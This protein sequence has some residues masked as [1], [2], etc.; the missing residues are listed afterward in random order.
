MR[1]LPLSLV[2][3]SSVASA[4]VVDR[5]AAVVEDEVISLSQVYDLGSDYIKQR[6]ATGG[7]RCNH[8]MELEVLD[9]LI[10]RVL[11]R[12]ELSRL[13]MRVTGKEIDQAINRMVAENG[14]ND[15]QELREA[16]ARE[17]VEWDAFRED[18]TE[19]MRMQ[20]FQGAVLSQR[21]VV[22]E[23]ELRDAYQRTARDSREEEISL[24]AMGIL[25]P[26]DADEEAAAA[27]VAA[28]DA[29]I[30]A[31]NAGEM[32]WEAAVA[33]HDSAGLSDIVG[34]RRYGPGELNQA[35]DTVAFAA[36]VGPVQPPIRVG[37]VLFVVRVT[38]KGLG[39]ARVVPYEEV[40][41]QLRNALFQ[42]KIAD[43]EEE[44]YQR[45]RRLAAVEILLKGPER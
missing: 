37:N 22:R 20:S 5:I 31:L 11:I 38:D 1:L 28:T 9:A 4:G 27:V 15:R 23:D 26:A 33:Q 14:M 21:V 29:V 32:T 40:E 36:E 45:A 18:L 8:E 12:E 19:S 41:A 39:E 10:K 16:L 7:P 17:G 13:G 3:L 25:I 42:A 2:L 43:A 24:D 35:V 44:W 30:A 34:G 6:C